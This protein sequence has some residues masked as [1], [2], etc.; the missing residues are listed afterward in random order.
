MVLAASWGTTASGHPANL[1]LSLQRPSD[2]NVFQV[3]L[4]SGTTPV[5]MSKIHQWTVHVTDAGGTPVSGA[6]LKI[7]G[8]MPEHGH[9]LPTAPKAAPGA[10]P[11][12]YVITGM[13]FSMKGWWVLKV[14]VRT[15]DG[16]ADQI[17]FNIVL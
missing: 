3:E 15:T 13:K 4:A 1:D 8:G 12:D 5:P 17:T 6:S 9:G 7:D 14:Y 16:R 10:T 11:G 2:R